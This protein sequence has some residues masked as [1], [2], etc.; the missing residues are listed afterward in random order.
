MNET[1][2]YFSML[3]RVAKTIDL[4]PRIAATE[5]VNFSNER[6]KA[7]NWVDNST[8]P[9]PKRKP[10]RGESRSRSNRAILVDTARLK[11]SIRVVEI[12]KDSATIGT[13]VPYALAHND[14]FRGTVTQ[15]V[16]SHTRRGRTVKAHSRTM[17]MNLPRRRFIGVSSV[18]EKRLER[19]ITAR[20][21]K[22]FKP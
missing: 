7:Q 22:S 21:I 10:T 16:R 12:R 5:A 3:D 6:F 11:R 18:L 17:Q 2:A 19:V 4:L 14:G 9:W 15:K 1:S 13:D 20:L 8:Q